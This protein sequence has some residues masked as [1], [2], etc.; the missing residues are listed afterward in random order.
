MSDKIDKNICLE[1]Y[2]NLRL[3]RRFDEITVDLMNNGEIPGPLHPA[4]G[5]EAI[6]VGIGT[7]MSDGDFL[8][9]SHRSISGQITRGA[10]VK[11]LLA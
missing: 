2:K 7:A 4:I 10:E 5:M 8:S 6:G 11:Y 1:M 9:A 3:S